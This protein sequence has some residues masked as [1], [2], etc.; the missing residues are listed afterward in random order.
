M[1]TPSVHDPSAA[2]RSTAEQDTAVLTALLEGAPGAIR[3]APWTWSALSESESGALTRTAQRWVDDY[4]VV[5]AVNHR[6]TVPVCWFR[7]PG[8]AHDL[9]VMVWVYFGSHHDRRATP[10]LAADYHLRHLPGFR[11]RLDHLLGS[12][13]ASCRAGRHPASWRSSPGEPVHPVGSASH[14]CSVE[15]DSRLSFTFGFIVR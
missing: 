1:T 10:H 13:P 4:N 11:S 2:S 14:E 15:S 5:H 12:D 6:E 8:L 9:A 3:R 7:H